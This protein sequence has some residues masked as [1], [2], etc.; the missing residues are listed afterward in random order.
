MAIKLI[1]DLQRIF[2]L[3]L[4]HIVL[5]EDYQFPMGSIH[6]GLV[7]SQCDKSGMQVMYQSH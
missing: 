5:F 4:V 2:F 7:I 6:V 3:G 1:Q